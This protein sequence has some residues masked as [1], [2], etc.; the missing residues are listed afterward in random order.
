MSDN[1]RRSGRS[2]SKLRSTRSAGRAASSSGMVVRLVSPL[3]TPF[4]P[5][6]RISRIYRAACHPDPFTVKLA[7]YLAG[8]VHPEVRLPHPA[9]LRSQLP[10]RAGTGP[11][12]APVHVPGVCAHSKWT[13]RS[14]TQHKS[15]RPRTPGGAHPR[16]RSSSRSA[17]ELRLREIRRRFPQDLIRPAQLTV[18]PAQI[19]QLSQL[20][21]AQPR[22]QPLIRL[23]PPNPLAQ[24]LGRTP[25]LLRYRTDR[26]PLRTMLPRCCNTNRTARSRTS[27]EYVIGLPMTPLSPN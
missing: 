13:G 17:V 10:R 26:R 12:T 23:S 24:R 7:P 14:A 1:Q 8:S 22:P 25:E 20:I 5:S 16:R 19:P 9:D 15:A 11:S 27:G 2:A 21:R 18:L 3:T 4:R 6:S